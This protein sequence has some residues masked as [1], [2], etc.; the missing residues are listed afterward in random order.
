MLE[1]FGERLANTIVTTDLIVGNWNPEKGAKINVWWIFLKRSQCVV[2]LFCFISQV[3]PRAL[4]Q[5]T[6]DSEPE[7]IVILRRCRIRN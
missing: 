6:N 1:T 4:F 7:R 2:E 3:D 5:E